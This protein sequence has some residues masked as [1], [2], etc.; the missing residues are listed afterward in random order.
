MTAAALPATLAQAV[1]PTGPLGTRRAAQAA[2]ALVLA[3]GGCLLIAVSAQI[4]VPMWPVPM[5]MQTFAV[6][7][8]GAMYGWRLGGATLALYLIAGA[9][10][11][12]VLASVPPPGE[13]WAY[14]TG[15]SGGYLAGFLVS[16]LLVGGLA[17]RGWDRTVLGT[18]ASMT[19]GTALI[20]GLGW[21]YLAHM[22]GP[23]AAFEQGVA[24]FVFGGLLKIALAAAVLPLAWTVVR[25]RTP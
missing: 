1:W 6:L 2:R 13:A 16:A 14:M 12:P 4:Q 24:P 10:G 8:V 19:L 23:A 21:A 7:L 25:R 20:L 3:L 18:L 9:L 5:T 22:I 15:P 11:L 17:E